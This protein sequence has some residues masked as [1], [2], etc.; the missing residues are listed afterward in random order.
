MKGHK[1][2]R[3]KGPRVRNTGTKQKC[4]GAGR[5][6]AREGCPSAD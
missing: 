3:R 1:M 6:A 4:V 5:C 2:L